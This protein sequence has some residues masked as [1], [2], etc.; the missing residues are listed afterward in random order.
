MRP[1]Q[2]G[3]KGMWS[4]W[5]LAIVGSLGYIAG[6][7]PTAVYLGPYLPDVIGSI[8]CFAALLILL[9]MWR[10]SQVLAYGGAPAAG[11][12]STEAHGLSG[13]DLV[14]AWLP[15]AVLV[16]VVVAW[17]GPWSHLPSIILLHYVVAANS[18]ITPGATISAIFNWTPFVGG[19]AILASWIIAAVL[20][21]GDFR[22]DRACNQFLPQHRGVAR[23]LITDAMRDVCMGPPRG[24][25]I[26]LVLGP[27]RDCDR[28]RE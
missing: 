28:T 10:P 26:V 24:S 20:L 15:I 21:R 1:N 27:Q 3:S 12:T 16:A 18:A 19:T 17:T 14:A 11:D 5:P 22:Q 9:K 23:T 6:Q 4:A 13:G 2:I 25:P 8:V 7:L